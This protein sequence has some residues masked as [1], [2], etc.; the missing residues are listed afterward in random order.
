[1]HVC[2]YSWIW[3]NGHSKSAC[4]YCRVHPVI[5]VRI[6][7]DPAGPSQRCSKHFYPFLCVALDGA[8]VA[9]GHTLSQLLLTSLPSDVIRL[10]LIDQETNAIIDSATRAGLPPIAPPS[11]QPPDP[12]G[13]TAVAK[14]IPGGQPSQP[15][16]A[17]TSSLPPPPPAPAK[18]THQAGKKQQQ[19]QVQDDKATAGAPMAAAAATAGRSANAAR[20]QQQQ[21]QRR[22][23]QK[24]AQTAAA[25]DA[26]AI[27][28]P[29]VHGSAAPAAASVP[30]PPL[31]HTAAMEA[32]TVPPPPVHHHTDTAVHATAA[33][34]EQA[35]AAAPSRPPSV[36]RLK[37]PAR[38]A[39][40]WQTNPCGAV[41]ILMDWQE[42]ATFDPK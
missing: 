2:I 35:A 9:V 29:H 22:V 10:Q 8:L 13:L 39:G 17:A 31:P 30:P 28:P 6:C 38:P 33:A 32:E 20:E 1:M 40:N 23:G 12:A 15:T 19:W 42:A 4:G 5:Q 11:G 7:E 41:F 34:V 21:Q 14:Q 18:Q 16:A 37:G 3:W 24:L 26:A 27:P 36:V 25:S